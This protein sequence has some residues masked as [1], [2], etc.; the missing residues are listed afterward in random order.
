MVK[1]GWMLERKSIGRIE[2]CKNK[3]R[4]L[5]FAIIPLSIVGYL[6]AVY[7]ESLFYL[8]EW[9]LM[10]L[11]AASIILAVISMIKIKSFL[12]WIS[13]SILA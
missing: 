9:M 2:I 1:Y 4:L 6:F 8:Y 3:R 12:K 11:F 7:K 13:A 5:L 10:L